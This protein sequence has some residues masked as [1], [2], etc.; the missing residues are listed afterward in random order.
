MA[1]ALQ[2]LKKTAMANALELF[3]PLS[4]LKPDVF[5]NL[6]SDAAFRDLSRSDGM[7]ANYLLDEEQVV[8]LREARQKAQEQA[9]MAEMA[10]QAAKSPALVEAMQ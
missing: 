10:M 9:Q 2:S 7:P 6:D 4:Q 5:D 3:L 8:S 1:L